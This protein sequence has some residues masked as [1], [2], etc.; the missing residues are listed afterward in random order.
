LEV[1]DCCNIHSRTSKSFEKSWAGPD[2]RLAPQGLQI[3]G[4]SLA[5]LLWQGHFNLFTG[6][7]PILKETAPHVRFAKRQFAE[8]P[9][10]LTMAT[11]IHL[12]AR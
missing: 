9:T 11:A 1:C 2:S 12:R 5:K 10:S 7:L 3:D 4:T 6:L 8:G